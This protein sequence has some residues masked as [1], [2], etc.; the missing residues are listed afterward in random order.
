MSLFR[1][2]QTTDAGYES[3]LKSKLLYRPE[4][5]ILDY[6]IDS[7]GGLANFV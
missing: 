4:K 7:V 6:L 2:F 1:R 5:C 3:V